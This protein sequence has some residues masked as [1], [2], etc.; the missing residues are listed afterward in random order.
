MAVENL[1]K[2]N[3]AAFIKS[4]GIKIVDYWADWCGP[5]KVLSPVLDELSL[6][7]ASIKIGKFDI[8]SDPSV[9]S[10]YRINS[11]PCIIVFDKSGAEISRQVGFSGKTSV[12]ELFKKLV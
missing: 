8:S 7:Y 11:I 10:Q 12:E 2:D 5:C 3:F 4:D 1:T 9:A 6:K